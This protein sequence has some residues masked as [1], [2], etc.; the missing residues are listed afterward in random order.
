MD[1]EHAHD[2]DEVTEQ[3]RPPPE[4]LV[5]QRGPALTGADWFFAHA[6]TMRAAHVRP[7]DPAAAAEPADPDQGVPTE[8]V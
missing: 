8:E 7:L 6:V 3:E 4:R 5:S 1:D 2:L